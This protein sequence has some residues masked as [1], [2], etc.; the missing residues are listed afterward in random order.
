MFKAYDHG[1]NWYLFLGEYI[2]RSCGGFKLF[3]WG[4]CSERS[5]YPLHWSNMALFYC[6][7]SRIVKKFKRPLQ[8]LPPTLKNLFVYKN[9]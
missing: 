1:I 8:F 3:L 4:V 9:F 6:L 2:Y 5:G 7:D